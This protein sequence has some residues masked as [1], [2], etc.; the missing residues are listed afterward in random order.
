M[1]GATVKLSLASNSDDLQLCH[2]FEN[3]ILEQELARK[4]AIRQEAIRAGTQQLTGK[5]NAF[6]I[7]PT[8]LVLGLG[9]NYSEW[10]FQCRPNLIPSRA[11]ACSFK[12]PKL[13][14]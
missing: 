7:F 10:S 2:T 6:R 8:A 14:L 3:L 1:Y 5:F 11:K 9:F 13:I 12:S 4:E